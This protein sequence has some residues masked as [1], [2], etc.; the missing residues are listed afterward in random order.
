MRTS[1]Q[2]LLGRN[3]FEAGD[4]AAYIIGPLAEPPRTLA[5]LNDAP[6]VGDVAQA[7]VDALGRALDT[8]VDFFT[9][10]WGYGADF[11]GKAHWPIPAATL[12]TLA[13][14]SRSPFSLM[15]NG[16]KNGVYMVTGFVEGTSQTGRF[17]NGVPWRRYRVS[18][19]NLICI[20]ESEWDR[21]TEEDE[22]FVLG[23]V[24]PHGGSAPMISWR[25]APYGGV[26]TGH[27]VPITRSY[28]V[29]VPLTYGF[30]SVACAVYES[31]NETPND[32]DL[33]LTDFASRVGSTVVEPEDSLAEVLGETI[34][35][36]WKLASVEAV[37]FR[38][39]PTV[40]VR[41]YQPR[42]FDQ[43]VDGGHQV[44]WTLTEENTWAVDVPD[45]I[46]CGHEACTRDVVFPPT[47]PDGERIDL[48]PKPGQRGEIPPDLGTETVIDLADLDPRCRR[49]FDP[50]DPG[51]TVDEPKE[52]SRPTDG[53]D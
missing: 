1:D 37:A 21:F 11:V 41:A 22:P 8:A 27:T 14:G 6:D 49:R 30:L 51:F 52:P 2:T 38:R 35:S 36:G 18:F 44:D 12:E 23:L 50:D 43:W 34:A 40:E 13:P 3:D 17:P 53:C 32:R 31:D 33:L 28:T 29:E 10:L 5:L 24:I 25:T 4:I 48:R 39:S 16:L 19:E 46:G 47:K 15:C 7:V 45:T 20:K 26:H 42:T 9:G